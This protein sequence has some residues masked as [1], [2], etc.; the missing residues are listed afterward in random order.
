MTTALTLLGYAA[1]LAVLGPR[2]MGRARWTAAAPRLAIATWLTLAASVV[3]AVVLAGVA[4][5]MPMDGFSGGPSGIVATC[6]AALQSRYGPVGGLVLAVIGA[7]LTW[8]TPILLVVAGLARARRTAAER[9]RLRSRLASADF[10]DALGAVVIVSRRPAAYCI[11]GSGGTVVVT[12]GAVDLVERDGLDAVLAHERAHL[13]G[14][15]HLLVALAGAAQLALGR[16][17]LFA[18]LPD[19]IGHLVEL[20]ADDAAARSANRRVLAR[21]LL[22]FATARTAEAGA[23]AISGGNTVAR[24]ERLL[25]GP[26]RPGIAG[27]GSILGGNAAAVAMP[28]VLA[29]VPM[30]TAVGMACCPV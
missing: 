24:I 8:L 29:A 18:V 17:P 9:A 10:D 3:L 26:Q 15:H 25:D 6:V 28:V 22:D 23:L 7:M 12:T 20:A 16:L 1:L 13:A 27:F 14:R 2:L 5:V 30:L 21:S 4:L 19:R 11:P